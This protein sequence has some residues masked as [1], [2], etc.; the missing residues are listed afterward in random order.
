[1][2]FKILSCNSVFATGTCFKSAKSYDKAVDAFEKAADAHYH[3]NAYPLYKIFLI[4]KVFHVNND[5][6]NNDSNN[7]NNN[8]NNNN[9]NM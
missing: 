7:N 9:N 5:N 1:M 6:N 4:M 2:A 8:D 3:V